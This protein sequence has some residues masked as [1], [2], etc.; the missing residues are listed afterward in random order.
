MSLVNK[1]ASSISSFDTSNLNVFGTSACNDE[2]MYIQKSNMKSMKRNYCAFCKKL[3]S[4]FA[5]HLETVHC[6]E[7]EVKK[8]VI[9]PKNDPERKKI[10]NNIR[11]FS[12]FKYNTNPDLNTGQ[13]IVCRRPNKK[14]NKTATDFI[15]CVKCKGFFA[16]STIRH[17]SRA[18]LTINKD[19]RKHK[20][21]M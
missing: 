18:C 1:T 20:N 16:K 4:Q 19:F 2:V 6:N 15:A 21:I 7:P 10:I 5:R 8:F 9:L 17:H 3:Q 11:K 14:V 13:L 12:N